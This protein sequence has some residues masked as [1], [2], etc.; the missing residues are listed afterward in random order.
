LKLETD[1]L[2]RIVNEQVDKLT[3]THQYY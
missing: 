1:F 2:N 3:S